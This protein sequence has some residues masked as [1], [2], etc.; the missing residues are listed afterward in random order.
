MKLH[1]S[2][3]LRAA[4]LACYSIAAPVALTLAT[5]NAVSYADDLTDE[6]ALTDVVTA[7]YDEDYTAVATASYEEDYTAVATA[8]Y[9]DDTSAAA[10]V[11]YD[12]DSTAPAT[13]DGGWVYVWGDEFNGDTLDETKWDYELGVI[14]NEGTQQA[15]TEEAVTVS[16][17]CLTITSTYVG[18]GSDGVYNVNY[19]GDDYSWFVYNTEYMPYSSGSVTTQNTYSFLYG[20]LEVSVKLPDAT[21]AWPAIW[22]LGT[23][24]Y[25]TG[26]DKDAWPLCGEIDILEHISQY[27]GLVYTTLHYTNSGVSYENLGYSYQFDASTWYD[28]FHV[29]AMEWDESQ[30]KIFVDDFCIA[31]FDLD[32]ISFADGENPFDDPQ[33]LILNT[34]IGGTWCEL[35]DDPS[36]YPVEYLIDYVRYYQYSPTEADRGNG[37]IVWDAAT[38]A[39]V[40]LSANTENLRSSAGFSSGDADIIVI[41]TDNAEY[42]K[43]YVNSGDYTGDIRVD[44]QESYINEGGWYAGQGTGTL[45][46]DMTMRFSGDSLGGVQSTAGSG[47]TVIG[48]MYGTI[49]GNL[50]MEFSNTGFTLGSMTGL[51]LSVVSSL[52]G[53]ITG[54]AT[55]VFN[56]GNYQ[57]QIVGGSANSTS[58][59]IG[60]DVSIYINGGV[61]YDEIIGGGISGSVTGSSSIDITGGTFKDNITA[62]AG[63]N[64]ISTATTASVTGATSIRIYGSTGTFKDGITINASTDLSNQTSAATMSIVGED[65]AYTH[66]L[67]YFAGTLTGGNTTGTRTL[68]FDA[69]NLDLSYATVTNFDKITLSNSSTVTL[70]ASANLS[71]STVSVASSSLSFAA[72]DSATAVAISNLTLTS[73]SITV[74]DNVSVVDGIGATNTVVDNSTMGVFASTTTINLGKDASLSLA[75]KINLYGGNDLTVTGDGVFSVVALQLGTANGDTSTITIGEGATMHITGTDAANAGSANT[76][77]YALNLGQYAGSNAINVAGTLILDESMGANAGS[78]TITV[79]GT[80]QLNSGLDIN[81]AYSSSPASTINIE[82]GGTLA[83]GTGTATADSAHLSVNMASGST[84]KSVAD[85]TIYESISYDDGGTI[86]F[87]G[88]NSTLS[89]ASSISGISANISGDVV[90]SAGATLNS[91]TLAAN[92]SLTASTLSSVDATSSISIASGATLTVGDASSYT[93]S[94]AVSGGALVFDDAASANAVNL[95]N[96][97]L[98]SGSVTIGDNVTVTEGDGAST[99]APGTGVWTETLTVNLGDNASLSSSDKLNIV[100]GNSVTVSGTGTYSVSGVQ[101]GTGSVTGSSSLI[102]EDGATMNITGSD[103]AGSTTATEYAFMLGNFDC[104]STITVNGTLNVNAAMSAMSGGSAIDVSGTLQLNMGLDFLAVNNNYGGANVSSITVKDGGTLKLGTGTAASDSAFLTVSMESGSTIES[105]ATTTVNENITYTGTT[106]FAGTTGTLTIATDISNSTGIANIS[107]NVVFA[108]VTTLATLDVA[109]GA[110]LTLSNASNTITATKVTGALEIA[111]GAALTGDI[112]LAGGSLTVSGALVNDIAVTSSSSLSATGLSSEITLSSGASLDL[113]SSELSIDTNSFSLVLDYELVYGSDYTIFTN[114][115]NDF[116][117]SLSNISSTNYDSTLFDYTWDYDAA[118]NISL[119]LSAI[120]QEP[121]WNEETGEATIPTD[122]SS[123]NDFTFNADENESVED[124]VINTGSTGT[125]TESGTT[126]TGNVVVTGE[127]DVTISGENDLAS[128]GTITV[129]DEDSTT[130]VIVSTGVTASEGIDVTNGSVT[131]DETGSITNTTVT[132]AEDTTLTAGNITVTGTSADT[133]VNGTVAADTLTDAAVTSATV[134]VTGDATLAGETTIASDSSLNVTEGILTLESG[135]SVEAD[136]TL[137]AGAA[138]STGVITV[139]GTSDAS[140]IEFTD[141][142]LTATGLASALVSEST[143]KVTGEATLTD[144]T[145]GANSTV[146]VSNEASLTVDDSIVIEVKEATGLA[147][148]VLGDSGSLSSNGISGA[149]VSGA[150]ITIK[151]TSSGTITGGSVAALLAG[152]ASD[153]ETVDS[154]KTFENTTLSDTNVVMGVDSTLNL[155]NVTITSDTTF[156]ADSGATVN[157]SDL[158]INVAE[159]DNLVI[160]DTTFTLNLF[161]AVSEVNVSGALSINLELSA[162]NFADLKAS[163]ESGDAVVFD[164]VSV[165]DYTGLSDAT[166]TISC[167]DDS[168]QTVVFGA[169]GLEEDG[170]SGTYGSSLVFTVDQADVIPEPST[171]TLSLLALA[172]LLARRRRK[173]A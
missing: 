79:T 164:V 41:D 66:S 56:G 121:T 122:S 132:L 141:G 107:G 113:G 131:V 43:V 75:D 135:S 154:T 125:E 94:V 11:T 83:L 53:N 69:A 97:N 39:T 99:T 50:Y 165:A 32:A 67:N 152:I 119:S 166:I 103:V 62:G 77:G 48:A 168:E 120:A 142:S 143:V 85:T 87:A 71:A 30:I 140:G 162:E 82:S 52:G 3:K 89:M 7:S 98:G 147:S 144:S 61:F 33:F 169:T 70:A 159:G 93:G 115:G 45:T 118:G 6:S 15:Y 124:P 19:V 160:N 137:A 44:F 151:G 150:T 110:S 146:E 101:L 128:S 60:G 35:A 47:V 34:A 173:Q 2:L 123:G 49:D 133:T 136:T 172:G 126:S 112:T 28:E 72:A 102:I 9:D 167:L 63:S 12:T 105:V 117:S 36:E 5:A 76:T 24:L 18:E 127:A 78:S 139:T 134:A 51:E 161:N 27:D 81:T 155:I 68:S 92:S 148:L 91:L 8:S 37:S 59:V 138:V 16:D 153:T 26:D 170:T 171:A 29:F 40:T 145:I 54:D 17:G 130:N 100:R 46:G 108:G 129:G 84:I 13:L 163:L 86:T 111:S 80:L 64:S 31:I 149:T 65:A 96:I 114:A 25:Y 156:T 1:L 57:Y 88:E 55:L 109:E 73:G 14:R 42:N 23:S 21:G 4:L 90:F 22:M 20:R 74:G 58:S 106:N 95:S 104:D 157:A 116:T 38:D 10:T 158:T